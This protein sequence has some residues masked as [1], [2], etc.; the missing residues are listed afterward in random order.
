M[1]TRLPELVIL[2]SVP[3]QSLELWVVGQHIEYLLNGVL[4]R[5]RLKMGQLHKLPEFCVSSLEIGEN[6]IK[7][8]SS[9]E[10]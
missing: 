4:Y 5:S 3:L 7:H 2:C 9:Q 1:M 6:N 10:D 8:H